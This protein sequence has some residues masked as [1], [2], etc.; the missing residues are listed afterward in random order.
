MVKNKTNL[1]NNLESS[2]NAACDIHYD[3]LDNEVLCQTLESMPLKAPVIAS[4]NDTLESVL[5][6][7]QSFKTGCVIIVDDNNIPIGIF[8]ERDFILKVAKQYSDFKNSS[9]SEFMTKD[10]V[11]QTL[12]CTIAYA[13]TLMSEGGFRNLP[14]VNSQNTPVGIIAVKDVIDFLVGNFMNKLLSFPVDV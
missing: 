12:D 14:I 2:M 11:V 7:L 4:I 10:P 8:T 3:L 6:S 1:T 5:N 13:L 9:I